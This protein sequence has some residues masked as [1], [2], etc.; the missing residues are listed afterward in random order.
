M[1]LVLGSFT[2]IRIGV[3]TVKAFSDSLKIN[4]IGVSSLEALAYN[5]KE[6]VEE[7]SYVCSIID[8]K[9]D[10]CYFAL[11]KKKNNIYA[12]IIKPSSENIENAISKIKISLDNITNNTSNS[13]KNFSITFVGDGS[14]IFKPTIEKEF[15][16]YKNIRN[17]KFADENLNNLNSY[18]LAL[19]GI[20][21]PNTDNVLPLYLKKPQAQKTLQINVSKMLLS[22]LDAISKT[23]SCD[24]DDFW[25]C[26]ILKEELENPNS[27]YIVAKIGEDI[28]G[29]AGFKQIA[30]EANVMNIVAKKSFRHQGIGSILLENLISLSEDLNMSSIT[31]E[32]SANN[33]YAIKL[34]EKFGFKNV[35]V[36]KNYYKDN[37]DAIIMTI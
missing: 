25:N 23:L 8:C 7:N 2:G 15:A 12:E 28:V 37:S 30:D 16:M 26:N 17:I 3:A 9:N 13:E 21:N 32:V 34:Y 18:S 6:I 35:G 24:F 1:T 27:H 33:I 36:R 19:A 14:Q 10:N 29:F 5:V 22:D 4:C 20:N 31:L 11:Y